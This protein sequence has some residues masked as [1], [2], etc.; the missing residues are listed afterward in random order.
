MMYLIIFK[1]TQAFVANLAKPIL[2]G[3]REKNNI[4]LKENTCSTHVNV[5]YVHVY[6]RKTIKMKHKIEISNIK[7]M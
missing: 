5:T 3:K 7:Y 4:R 2:Q 1:M 6:E